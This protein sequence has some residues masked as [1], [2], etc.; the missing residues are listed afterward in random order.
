MSNEMWTSTKA[1]DL[2]YNWVDE[3]KTILYRTR[4]WH[5]RE[6]RSH[7]LHD[8]II[9]AISFA[10][11]D[12]WQE[13]VLE[14]PHASKEGHHKIAYTRSDEHGN[15]DRQTVTSVAKYLTRHFSSM[16]SDHIRN[17]AALYVEATF[18]IVHTMEEMLDIIANGPNSCMSGDED[19]FEY[20]HG[21]HPYETY[22]PKYGWHM[23]CA[24]EN[25]VYT[26]RALLN[27]D[28]YVRTYRARDGGNY[29]DSDER[30]NAWLQEQEYSKISD[31][32]GR[33]LLKLPARNDNG[34]VAP[35]LDGDAKYVIDYGDHLRITDEE[36]DAE[37]KCDNT[38]GSAD[39]ISHEA[40]EDCGDSIG[41]GDGHWVNQSEDMYICNHCRGNHY[42][43]VIGRRGNEYAVHEDHAVDVN[44][45][46]Y[47]MEYMSDNG[48]V[49]L[50]NGEYCKEEDAVYMESTDAVY[51][52]STDAWYEQDD[53]DICYTVDGKY[54][55]REDCVELENG[56]WCLEDDAWCCDHSGDYY[57]ASE[58]DSVTTKCGKIVHEDHADQ[59]EVAEAE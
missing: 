11:P 14:W 24:M 7:V 29:S 37:Y 32:S 36:D 52:E 12:N 4:L 41:S 1:H 50:S 33:K 25:G 54:E 2:V 58:H 35:Y 19:R 22:D 45:T 34:F 5:R 9:R 49:E 31:W 51:M 3:L 39:S 13:M 38:D 18:K 43:W 15:A 10:K 46:W 30:L 23:A 57:Q 53:I 59:Y 26:G 17:I 27:D 47:H 44:G 21:R 8:A 55:M 48:V 40:C 56:E 6:Q 28:A 16:R 42:T 20:L